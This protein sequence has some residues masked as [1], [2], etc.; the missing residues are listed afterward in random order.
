MYRSKAQAGS[1][2][3]MKTMVNMVC[4][5]DFYMIMAAYVRVS[6]LSQND[7]V[8]YSNDIYTFPKILDLLLFGMR[9]KFKSWRL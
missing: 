4:E 5:D 2:L 7:T 3:R 6:L 9:P 1:D 8:G